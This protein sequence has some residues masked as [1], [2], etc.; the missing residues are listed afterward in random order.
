M[1]L[2]QV[3]SRAREILLTGNIEEAA[4]ESEILLRHVL[5]ISR[6]ELYLDLDREVSPEQE[7][8]FFKL[9]KRRLKR[10][11]TAYIT[12]HVEFYGLDFYVDP[13][14]L[15]PRPESELL[16]DE[17]LKFAAGHPAR[18]N[19]PYL[20]AE[21]GTGSGAIAIA[22]GR[23]LPQAKIYASDISAAA[24]E[25]A[26]TNCHRHGVA[27]VQLLAGNM[28]AALP[29]PVDLVV[30]NLPYVS[31]SQMEELSPEIQGFE[32]RL[33]LAGGEDGLDRIGELCHGLSDRLR[34]QGGLLLEIGREQAEPVATLLH[35]LF[36]S[37]ITVI[38][39]LNGT[40]RV[41]LLDT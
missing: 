17:A 26:A 5:N 36:A 8:A 38:P 35:S 9:V 7:E 1:T 39:D 6:V 10:E 24:L 29:E 14:V 27:N 11:P 30:A 12:G 33:A 21:A 16:V 34:P 28:L 37:E 15:I 31:D 20:I 18:E 19:E 3:L 22:L 4:L 2:K 41:I 25:V 23:H 13:R 32:P 40:D